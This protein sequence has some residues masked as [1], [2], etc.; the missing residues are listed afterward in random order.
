MFG[1]MTSGF[2]CWMMICDD[3]WPADYK[4]VDLSNERSLYRGKYTMHMRIGNILSE[5]DANTHI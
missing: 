4:L 3:C 2:S 1:S 5:T